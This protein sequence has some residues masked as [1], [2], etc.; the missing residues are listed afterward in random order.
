M[1][2]KWG[3]VFIGGGEPLVGGEKPFKLILI[4]DNSSIKMR[5]KANRSNKITRLLKDD[6]SS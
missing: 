3:G 4:F 2:F 5:I 6:P 1:V